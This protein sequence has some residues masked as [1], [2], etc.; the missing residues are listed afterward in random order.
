MPLTKPQILS[1]LA[2][3]DLNTLQKLYDYSA[4]I[5][6]PDKDLLTNVT[7][8]EIVAKAYALAQNDFPEWTDRS[9]ADFGVFLVELMG[10]F[11]EKDFWYINAFANQA[12]LSRCT[13]YSIAF[14]R[15]VELGGRPDIIQSSSGQ[16]SVTFGPGAAYTYLPGTIIFTLPDGTTFT[17]TISYVLALS[18]V[19][20]IQSLT[21][22]EGVY[23]SESFNFDGQSVNIRRTGVVPGT[24]EVSVNGTPWNRVEIFGQSG[25]TSTDY[26]VL[27]EDNDTAIIVFGEDGYGLKPNVND[28]I[29]V[30]YLT[31]KG[32]DGNVAIQTATVTA[33]SVSRPIT[34]V[35]MTAENADGKDAPTLASLVNYTLNYFN[36]RKAVLNE[37]S[38]KV[39]LDEQAETTQQNTAMQG[40]ILYFTFTGATGGAPTNPERVAVLLRITP[41]VGNGFTVT[42]V[43]PTLIPITDLTLDYYYL[44]GA[45]TAAMEADIRQR[46]Q[47]YCNPA[48]RAE[49]G[50][51]FDLAT[52]G[53]EIIANVTALQNLVFT[54]VNGAAAADVPVANFEIL[55]PVALGS[56]TLNGIAV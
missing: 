19:P 14:I 22:Y 9:E 20:V 18:G 13:V 50:Q 38:A 33:D 30:K 53:L 32:A 37:D 5:I 27:P 4:F 17:N 11:S 10:L 56:I 47:D 2:T 3:L 46:L 25:P 35:T 7:M 40:S 1:H 41:L 8:R 15:A 28:L 12:I 45:D 29:T 54:V 44:Q 51:S 21:F 52:I 36:Y 34:A 39:W 48:V 55:Q 6:I 23:F 24:V 31:C 16:F 26:M 43:A 42:Y 49:F